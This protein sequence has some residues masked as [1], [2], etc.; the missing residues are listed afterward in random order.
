MSIEYINPIIINKNRISP[1]DVLLCFS[2]DLAEQMKD[3]TGGEYAHTAIC[4]IDGI[5]ADSAPGGVKKK[6]IS[7]LMDEY[8]YI[9]VIR[10]KYLWSEYKLN[11][12]NLFVKYI[13]DNK[14]GFN[15]KGMAK[16]RSK[17][18]CND[19]Q[20]KKLEDF[21][22]NKLKPI[23][24]IQNS[25]FCSELVTA[26]FY[27]SEFWGDDVA[28]IFN[29]RESTPHSISQ[30]VTYGEFIG[31]LLPYEEYLIPESDIYFNKGI[32]FEDGKKI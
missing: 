26:A 17:Q 8:S 1:G 32:Y 28:I 4:L 13:I 30:E 19:S 18:A 11:L 25:Y 23:S 3:N 16:L 12:L 9:A 6:T 5:V 22:A 10:N 31:Y 2:V 20:L 21:F 15:S 14:A 27:A 7:E 24:P 29:Q